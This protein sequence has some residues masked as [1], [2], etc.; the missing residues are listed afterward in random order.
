[1]KEQPML[2]DFCLASK[3]FP[4]HLM[5]KA[6]LLRYAKN[7][8]IRITIDYDPD[9]EEGFMNVFNRTTIHQFQKPE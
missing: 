4:K 8:R 9:S 7:G 6:G 2:I 1:M 5:E 3:I